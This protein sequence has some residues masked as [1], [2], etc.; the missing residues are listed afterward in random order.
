LSEAET[1]EMVCVCVCIHRPIYFF[2]SCGASKRF[3]VMA[4][5]YGASRPKLLDAPHSAELLCTSDQPDAGTSTWQHTQQ[6]SMPPEGF[7]TTVPVSERTETHALERAA[8]RIGLHIY[9]VRTLPF[10]TSPP[11]KRVV[12]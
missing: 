3:R 2:L 7:E 1:L 11:L 8:T 6:T 4:S 12:V 5:L 9:S 10:Y